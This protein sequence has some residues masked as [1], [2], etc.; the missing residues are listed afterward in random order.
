[1]ATYQLPPQAPI[2]STASDWDCSEVSAMRP[3]PGSHKLLSDK[4]GDQTAWQPMG[5]ENTALVK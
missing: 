1:M 3:L 2:S 5:V 4:Q